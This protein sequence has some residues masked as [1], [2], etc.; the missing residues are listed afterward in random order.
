MKWICAAMTEI[1][2]FIDHSWYEYPPTTK[3]LHPWK[4]ETDIKYTGPKP[5]FEHLDTTQKRTVT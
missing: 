5:P 2:E 1:Q 3:G 4:G